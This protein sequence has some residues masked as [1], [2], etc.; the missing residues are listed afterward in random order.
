MGRKEIIVYRDRGQ[1]QNTGTGV[2]LSEI[3]RKELNNRNGGWGWCMVIYL[4]TRAR[5]KPYS[6]KTKTTSHFTG[7][8]SAVEKNT[9]FQFRSPELLPSNL[10]GEMK[11]G[12]F[13][14]FILPSN[15]NQG[16]ETAKKRRIVSNEHKCSASIP[17]K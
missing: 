11:I 13:F 9:P 8:I 16:Y 17:A 15:L 4:K 5:Q 1:E 2:C 7:M 10:S 14:F 6:W 3:K 12:L